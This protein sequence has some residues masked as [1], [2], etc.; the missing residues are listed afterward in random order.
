MEDKEIPGMQ[1]YGETTQIMIVTVGHV[2]SGSGL[3][4]FQTT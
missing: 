4:K 1:K 2:T 3:R